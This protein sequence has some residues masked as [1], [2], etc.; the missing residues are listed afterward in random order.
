MP[1]SKDRKSCSFLDCLEK[2]ARKASTP[3]K[4]LPRVQQDI[5]NYSQ[6]D[7]FVFPSLL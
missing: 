7:N 2:V 4:L 6:F 1:S 5:R 3:A